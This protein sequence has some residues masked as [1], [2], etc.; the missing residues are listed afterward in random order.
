MEHNLVNSLADTLHKDQAPRVWSL[1]VAVFGELGQ[2]GRRK[3][4]G[5][6]LGELTGLMGIKPEATR[7]ALHRLKKDGWLESEK[8]GRKSNYFLSPLGLAKSIDATPLIYG[9]TPPSN[10]AWVVHFDPQSSCIQTKY[11]GVWIAPHILL[12]PQNFE[13]E[14]ALISMIEGTKPV[15]DWV[16]AKVCTHSLVQSIQA[17]T[18]NLRDLERQLPQDIEL[19]PLEIAALRILIVHSW[20]RIVLKT[21]NLTR[22]FF[23]E[24]WVG[25]KCRS[26]VFELLSHLEPQDIEDLEKASSFC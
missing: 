3:I 8:V 25:D 9:Q 14:T 10:V 21:P 23:P 16:S 4:S 2:D 24:G 15:P 5:T 18:E 7:V 12:S 22:S 1:L 17:L 20:R 11:E 26:T 13:H 19:A 6:L